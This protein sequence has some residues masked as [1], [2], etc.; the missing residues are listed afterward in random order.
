MLRRLHDLIKEKYE[1]GEYQ[2]AA[3]SYYNWK[4]SIHSQIN[5]NYQ[6]GYDQAM[7]DFQNHRHFHHYPDKIIN[8]IDDVTNQRLEEV[9]RFIRG[10]NAG[11]ESTKIK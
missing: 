10:Y 3:N 11:I 9:N 8:F 2:Q 6:L 5:D 7:A 4:R 1:K